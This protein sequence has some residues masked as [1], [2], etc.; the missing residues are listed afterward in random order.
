MGVRGT[1]RRSIRRV[2]RWLHPLTREQLLESLQTFGPF[3]TKSLLV[4]SALSACGHIDGGASTVINALRSWIGEHDLVMPTHSYCYPDE[5]GRT[6]R[7]NPAVTPSLVGAITNAFWRQPNVVRSLHPTHS[8][9]CLGAGARNLCVGH[10]LCNTPCG[11]GTPYEKLILQD[12]SV[13]MFG[14]TLNTYTLFHTAEDAAQVPYLYE[15]K[16][17]SLEVIDGDGQIRSVGMRRHDMRIIRCF[18]QMDRWLEKHALLVRRSLG[19]GQLLFI[20]NAG[21]AH[22]QLVE[23]LHIDPFLLI[24]P[25][26]RESVA[27]RFKS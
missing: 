19:F 1:I 11:A 20:P 2:N 3:S 18:A 22:H 4:H 10:E 15:Q 9:A 12:S 17:Y 25:A 14:V 23:A 26:V 21:A 27:E 7:F 6:P 24:A 8:L 13:L 5:D 16:P